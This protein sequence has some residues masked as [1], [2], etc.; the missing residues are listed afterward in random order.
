MNENRKSFA[1]P[2]L[3]PIKKKIIALTEKDFELRYE[4][5][6][7]KLRNFDYVCFKKG[8]CK[9]L[10]FKNYLQSYSLLKS[11]KD[12][13]S[14][15]YLNSVIPFNTNKFTSLH[16]SELN[17]F[18]FITIP[19]GSQ[20]K[21]P[22]VLNNDTSKNTFSHV[23]VLA[24]ENSKIT[25]IDK[26]FSEKESDYYSKCV[27]LILKDNAKINYIHL[28]NLKNN[29]F[30]FCLK[31]AKTS[32]D[33]N[34]KW[35]D[36]FTGSDFCV[37]R[38]ESN[39]E[40]EGASTDSLGVFI[41]TNNQQFDV[42]NSTKHVDPYTVSNIRV[43]NVFDDNSKCIYNGLIRIGKNAF[44]SSGYQKADALTLNET[45]EVDA[46]PQLEIENH[47][48]KCSHGTT[49]GE[50]DKSQMF[51]LMS[52]GLSEKESKQI[53]VSGFIEPIIKEIP[54]EEIKDEVTELVKNKIK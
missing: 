27:E 29:R 2:K 38:T 53:I 44:K 18:M 33:S 21:E 13:D 32:K 45:A 28:Q 52:R 47:D 6:K 11:K 34:V 39:L 24:E 1:H 8:N 54:I 10:E 4:K 31:K 42:N 16:Y 22:I 46:V 51:Y 14:L 15:D 49:M 9:F 43:K 3:P 30:N 40:K 37:S 50:I 12:K 19:K 25:I 17:D 26:D 23:I 36:L 5:I 48:V 41:G 35:F 7:E 20:N